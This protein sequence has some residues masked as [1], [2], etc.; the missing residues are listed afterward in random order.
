MFGGGPK[1]QDDYTKEVDAMK[2]DDLMRYAKSVLGVEVR[3]AGRAGK[4]TRY[5]TVDVVKRSARKCRPLAS[6]L[7]KITI[8]LRHLL[9]LV[10]ILGTDSLLRQRARQARRKASLIGKE[11]GD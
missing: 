4:K 9:K 5:R 6:R 3:Q 10:Q 8:R 2:K 1:A 7:G 11:L